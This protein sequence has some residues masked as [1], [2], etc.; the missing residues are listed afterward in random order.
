[1]TD[2]DAYTDQELEQALARVLAQARGEVLND[3]EVKKFWQ[4]YEEIQRRA[5]SVTAA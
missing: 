3:A 2:L 1:M 4:L 5:P